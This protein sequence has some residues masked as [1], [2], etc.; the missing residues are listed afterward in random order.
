MS[1]FYRIYHENNKAEVIPFHTV[2]RLTSEYT[3]GEFYVYLW[4]SA[5]IT[6]EL[7][8]TTAETFYSDYLDWVEEMSHPI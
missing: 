6:L 1:N 2:S 8:G 5:G 7:H 4:L 3:G